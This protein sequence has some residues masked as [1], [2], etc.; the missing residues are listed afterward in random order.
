[1]SIATTAAIAIGAGVA[2]SVASGIGSSESAG[3]QENAAQQA[4]SLEQK[5]QR[6]RWVFK[7]LPSNNHSRT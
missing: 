3:A 6:R 1:M 2:G 5:N 4:Q 7:R